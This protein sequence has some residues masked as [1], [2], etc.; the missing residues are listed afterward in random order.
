MAERWRDVAHLGHAE[1]LTPAPEASLE[2]LTTLLGLT[3]VADGGG[4]WFLRGHGDY[5]PYS[6]KL[7]ASDHPGLGHLA[8]RAWSP[9][10]LARRV[11]WLEQAGVPAAW[12]EPEGGKGAG[13]RSARAATWGST[14][15]GL[16]SGRCDLVAS[17][18]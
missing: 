6:L 11:R 10:A 17:L 9:E 3:V 12:T 15:P 5:E 2:Y 13:S 1:L 18:H 8:A 16:R 4:S 14:R 7:T